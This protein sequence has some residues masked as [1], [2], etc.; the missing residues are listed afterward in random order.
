MVL[1][2]A[3]RS[4]QLLMVTTPTQVQVRTLHN[5]S[6]ETGSGR[7]VGWCARRLAR[8]LLRRPR[9]P[10]AVTTAMATNASVAAAGAAMVDEAQRE[11]YCRRRPCQQQQRCCG[12]HKPSGA[13]GQGR[14]AGSYV[15]HRGR[16]LLRRRRGPRAV[17]TA[18][19]TNV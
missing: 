9:E 14:A 11:H 18:M 19:A 15:R 5:P 2:R 6:G 13:T 3:V 12:Q 7:V 1:V 8:K 16:K 4:L 17:M 10:R